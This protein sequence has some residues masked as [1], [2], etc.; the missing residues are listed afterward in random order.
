MSSDNRAAAYDISDY[1]LSLGH[2]RVEVDGPQG[3]VSALL[4]AGV[5]VV[6]D[7]R[8]DGRGEDGG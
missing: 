2:R 1:V 7:V 4:P 5:A 3:G 8:G 6:G